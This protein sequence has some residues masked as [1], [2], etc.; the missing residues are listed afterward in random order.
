MAHNGQE[1]MKYNIT[2]RRGQKLPPGPVWGEEVRVTRAACV[3]DAGGTTKGTIFF[4]CGPGVSFLWFLAL[5]QTRPRRERQGESG[6][7]RVCPGNAGSTSL[8]TSSHS[9]ANSQPLYTT[10]NA[11][12]LFDRRRGDVCSNE[13]HS[14]C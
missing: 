9:P 5:I 1:G 4:V 14:C 12:V 8:Q 13:R 7:S 6:I 3:T 2:V 10:Q 11:P